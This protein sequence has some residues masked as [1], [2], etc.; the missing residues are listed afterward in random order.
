MGRI[1]IMTKMMLSKKELRKRRRW[2]VKQVMEGVSAA[3]NQ[4]AKKDWSTSIEIDYPRKD[5]TE[6]RGGLGWLPEVGTGEMIITIKLGPKIADPPG[7][8]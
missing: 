5:P 6:I 4:A 1:Y 7:A 2:S 3:V 8:E